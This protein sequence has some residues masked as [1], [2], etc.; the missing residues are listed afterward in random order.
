MHGLETIRRLN[1]V[2]APTLP[3]QIANLA[4]GNVYTVIMQEYD[5]NDEH[6]KYHVIEV[7]VSDIHRPVAPNG[8]IARAMFEQHD[9]MSKHTDYFEL[10]VVLEGGNII[11]YK[12]DE[13]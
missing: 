9:L 10:V 3:P 2:K 13:A 7:T 1:S 8:W 5:N 4:M 6:V 12:P 11:A